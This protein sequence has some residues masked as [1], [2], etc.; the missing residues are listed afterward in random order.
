VILAF[1]H[2]EY[3]IGGRP[4]VTRLLKPGESIVLDVKSKLDSNMKPAGIEL[5][6]LE[7][8]LALIRVEHEA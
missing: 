8:N 7:M 2:Q 5:C 1:A 6:R 3:V 4:F